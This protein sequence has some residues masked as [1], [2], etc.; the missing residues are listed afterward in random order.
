M[1][2][3]GEQSSDIGDCRTMNRVVIDGDIGDCRRV[4]RVVIEGTVVG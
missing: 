1:L 3:E 2:S 4:N